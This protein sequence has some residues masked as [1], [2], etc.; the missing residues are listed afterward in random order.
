MKQGH[1]NVDAKH[2][3]QWRGVGDECA[4]I[5]LSGGA[6]FTSFKELP[7]LALHRD[8]WEEIG[9]RMGWIPKEYLV[10]RA[11]TEGV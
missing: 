10:T 11:L 1:S 8:E 4:R 2:T 9:I 6:S 3:D 7:S 5:P